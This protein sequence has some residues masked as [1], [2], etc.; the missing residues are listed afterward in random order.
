[1]SVAYSHVFIRLLMNQVIKQ[2]ADY[3]KTQLP[4]SRSL[5]ISPYKVPGLFLDQWLTSVFTSWPAFLLVCHMGCCEFM[6]LSYCPDPPIPSF[7]LPPTPNWSF[8]V[9]GCQMTSG[10]VRSAEGEDSGGGGGVWKVFGLRISSHQEQLCLQEQRE[11]GLFLVVE[12]YKWGQSLKGCWGV[13]QA[14]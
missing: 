11:G 13:W 9:L 4:F 2:K 3:F 12:G 1:M 6:D 14:C 8:E 10:A 7:F 5:L